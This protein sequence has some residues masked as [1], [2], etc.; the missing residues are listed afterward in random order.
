MQVIDD[1]TLVARLRAGDEAAYELMVRTYGGRLLAVA[2]G[3]LRQ[4]EDAQD[5]VQ[6]A[7][8]SAF[9]GLASFKGDC[10]LSTWLHRIVVTTALMKLRTRRRKP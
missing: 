8:M 2:R 5:C 6:G 3:L 1:A 10:Q 9:K 7:Y 4:E